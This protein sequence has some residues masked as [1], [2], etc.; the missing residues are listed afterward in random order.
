MSHVF[1]LLRLNLCY[2]NILTRYC[3]LVQIT[4]TKYCDTLKAKTTFIARWRRLGRRQNTEYRECTGFISSRRNWSPPPP[5]PQESVDTP[6]LWVQGGDTLS[7]EGGGGDWGTRFRR[8][9]RQSGSLGICTKIRLRGK[10][11]S[12]AQKRTPDNKYYL[13]IR[14]YQ[15]RRFDSTMFKTNKYE[16]VQYSS[17]VHFHQDVSGLLQDVSSFA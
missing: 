1:Y 15:W 2:S 14:T 6:F 5:H 3:L 9:D 10:V 13:G 7:S 11:Y 12:F 8:C 4:W 16:Y 17:F